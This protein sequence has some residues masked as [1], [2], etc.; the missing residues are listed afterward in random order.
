MLEL[1]GELLQP[2]VVFGEKY[3]LE[4]PLGAG[5]MGAVWAAVDCASGATV[6]LKVLYAERV[7]D[8]KDRARFV[9]EAKLAM[10]VRHANV[11]SVHAVGETES[12]TPFLVMDLLEGES[13]R[14]LL[15]RRTLLSPEECARVFAGILAGVRAAHAL[16]IVHR[17][18]KPENVFLV[19]AI[20]QEPSASQVRV[21]DFGVAKR[22]PSTI[23]TTTASASLTSTGAI[24]GTPRYMAPE[25]IFGATDLDARADVWAL[26]VMLFEALTGTR[27]TDGGGFG[28]IL[29]RITVDP[30]PTL[31][32][33]RPSLPRTLD[34]VDRMLSRPREQRPSLDDVT[35]M[36]ARIE[37]GEE[38]VPATLK[39]VG[40]HGGTAPL[41]RPLPHPDN[42]TRPVAAALA[43]APAPAPVEVPPSRRVARNA[44]I[45]VAMLVLLGG[46][47]GAME[48]G[49]RQ[50]NVPSAE[51]PTRASALSSVDV[52]ATASASASALVSP[53]ASAWA[54]PSTTGPLK[55]V[56]Y[57]RSIE[58]LTAAGWEES[59]TVGGEL[60]VY[61]KGTIARRS[62][63]FFRGGMMLTITFFEARS[64]RALASV[65]KT[66][67][68]DRKAMSVADP[69]LFFQVSAVRVVTSG[70]GP[71]DPKETERALELILRSP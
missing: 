43:P 18:L 57:E 10:A 71:Y 28:E 2:G 55:G 51:P 53:R 58:R 56:T 24:V 31:R 29:R 69:P 12:G 34:L 16:G 68:E 46:G 36:L 63:I 66:V 37:S 21:L 50:S 65:T 45:L 7:G 70:L 23:D 64:D 42:T 15:Q 48:L 8:A 6:V 26:G 40:E 62:Q 33:V 13:M 14:A 1:M 54:P 59:T 67:T 47:F 3:R 49:R 38:A 27:P 32:S 41:H 4:R 61:A 17:D 25:Q 35:A 5:G 52:N 11:A 22:M 60:D 30:L 44:S 9:R 20:G 39:L 19:G